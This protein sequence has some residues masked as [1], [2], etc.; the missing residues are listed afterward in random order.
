MA[1]PTLSPSNLNVTRERDRPFFEALVQ[2]LPSPVSKTEF[3]SILAERSEKLLYPDL[4]SFGRR[5]QAEEKFE[6][7][8]ELY[9]WIGA[10]ADA[11][12]EV[13]RPALREA[14]ALQGKGAFGSRAEVLLRQV[15]RDLV[16]A[17]LILPMIGASVVGQFGKAVTMGRLL[18]TPVGLFTRGSGAKLLATTAGFGAEGLAFAGLGRA[19][20]GP[21]QGLWGE[22]IARSY[23][24][25]GALKF[26]GWMG[27]GLAQGL[28]ARSPWLNRLQGQAVPQLTMFGGLLLAHKLEAKFGLRPEMDSDHLEAHTIAA[29]ISLQL[30]TKLGH[31][32][33]GPGFQRLQQEM[34]MAGRT[35]GADIF[36]KRPHVAFLTDSLSVPLRPEGF[37]FPGI[38]LS[39]GGRIPE[40]Q[41][42]TPSKPPISLSPHP[43]V[44]LGEF[45]QHYD[46]IYRKL[47]QVFGQVSESQAERYL[48]HLEQV[49]QRKAFWIQQTERFADVTGEEQVRFEQDIGI[50]LG[51]LR[52]KLFRV[53]AEIYQE[54]LQLEKKPRWGLRFKP[55]NESS[56]KPERSPAKPAADALSALVNRDVGY[57][58]ELSLSDH[59]IAA[60]HAL[61][62]RLR[63]LQSFVEE[64]A[65]PPPEALAGSIV[66]PVGGGKT[67][68][69]VAGFAAALEL[70]WANPKAGD[71][72]II[73][74]HTDQIHGQNLKVAGLLSGY[75]K[76]QAGRALKISEYK[77]DKKDVSGDVVV[78][79]I[80]SIAE[81]I[82]RQA[83]QVQLRQALGDQGKVA[84][85]AVDEVHHLGLGL[86]KSR[87]TW[88]QAIQSIRDLSP[89]LFQLGFTATPT[90]KEAGRLFTV[91]ELE[92]MQAGVTPRTYLV[93]VDG[94]DLSQLKITQTGEFEGRSL[95]STLLGHP[96]RNQR[97]YA[98]LDDRGMRAETPSPSGRLKLEPVLGFGQDLRHAE[99][100]A[101]DYLGYFAKENGD[102]GS[103]RLLVL[104]K[105]R[106]KISVQEL[107]AALTKY[108]EGKID[109]IVALVSGITQGQKDPVLQAVVRGEIEAVFTVDALV[110][111]ADLYMFSHQIGAR[112][113]FSRFKKGQERG[114]INRRGPDET[115]S[116]GKLLKDPPKIL[117][118][119]VD[120]YHGETP[121]I[122]YGDILGIGGHTQLK[123]GEML[124]A[125]SGEPSQEVD[126]S[127]KDITRHKPGG[128]LPP[129]PLPRPKAL[130]P[131]WA[132]LIEQLEKILSE[133]YRGDLESLALDLGET[134]GFV[135]ELLEG[136]AWENN[137]WF[138][139]RLGT[140]LYQDRQDFVRLYRE[141]YLAAFRQ[142]LAQIEAKGKELSYTAVAD[143]AWR[144]YGT[145]LPEGERPGRWTF[146]DLVSGSRADPELLALLESSALVTKQSRT[147]I[148]RE[149]E[150]ESFRQ[151]L[152]QIEVEGK[153]LSYTAMAHLAW[154]LYGE[155]L[156]EGE[157][158]SRGTFRHLV[159]GSGAD[160]ELLALLSA[161]DLV[162]K[163]R[164]TAL[165]RAGVLE[166]FRQALAQIEAEGK[167][168]SY[169]AVADLARRLYGESIPEG[170][171][172][173]RNTFRHLVNGSRADPELLALLASSAWVNKQSQIGLKRE[174]VLASFRQALAQIEGEGKELSYQ[175]VADLACRLYGESLPAGER[176]SRGTF[177]GLVKGSSADPE[178]PALLAA[179]AL[180]NKRKKTALKRKDVLESFRHALAKIEA[181]GKDVSYQAV[182]DLAGR[183]YG[184]SLPEGERPCQGSFGQLVRGSSVDPEVL[185][186]L[187]AS[188]LVSKQRRTALKR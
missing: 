140:L 17:K 151:A 4:L 23:V 135:T 162:S 112:P 179:S 93:K 176:P 153:E 181:E 13:K 84:M 15:T 16:D 14:E 73:L 145:G 89:Q 104:G 2:Q 154:R 137:R 188:D 7:A 33:L 10:Q 31:R 56:E 164:R 81:P 68:T 106:G 21:E 80:P 30:G 136:R 6:L 138:L 40:A 165:K 66:M 46:R 47:K 167:E 117:F 125:L 5:L 48:S 131:D 69:M 54:P 53:G 132:P 144:L 57:G 97:I 166:S 124:D 92:L 39:E 147:V 42:K 88:A 95:Q 27:R 61:R 83:F 35:G 26:S 161:S 38:S 58:R 148:K 143:L 107:Q 55:E 129:K 116:D 63:I 77:A 78:V 100:L 127:G 96:E 91:R 130:D 109:G 90:G 187:S 158:P 175:A 82:K 18:R 184:E 168:L 12:E 118:D 172:P 98:A 29:M 50:G 114:R 9:A 149:G 1:G 79:S 62:G 85:V 45:A 101:E 44:L 159:I 183:L 22:A 49:E 87:E 43:S 20:H 134:E 180:V 52:E 24:G 67:R 139:K 163:Q 108:R 146:R 105:N 123:N 141:P 72:L 170:E 37:A 155:G 103:R 36:G 157:R 86:G 8:L 28:P 126:R 178:L 76:K 111:G 75:F 160:P 113:T 60:L 99:S 64:G 133:H 25:L 142:A 110:E 59:Q 11:P 122:R 71:K 121:L 152:A 185:A 169:H 120:R 174:G 171:P 94:I 156:P 41:R 128:P 19:F 150:L 182:A 115:S 34:E 74:N 65:T 51:L 3:L 186:L 177:R 102:L 119:V 173:S 32:L 70:A